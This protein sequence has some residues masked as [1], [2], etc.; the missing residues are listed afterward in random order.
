[1]DTR[2]SGNRPVQVQDKWYELNSVRDGATVWGD[3]GEAVWRDAPEWMES[4]TYL[5]AG[6]I[7]TYP[8]GIMCRKA[9]C[10]A[11]QFVYPCVDC[12]DFEHGDY[13]QTLL[14]SGWEIFRCAPSVEFRNKPGHVHRMVT[15]RKRFLWSDWRWA[16]TSLER[17]TEFAVLAIEQL[18]PD[19]GAH[20]NQAQCLSAKGRCVWASGS[21]VENTCRSNGMYGPGVCTMFG[22]APVL[23]GAR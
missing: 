21:C 20:A 1:M 4:L 8:Y 14:A 10:M 12:P 2:A 7:W 17:P 3:I 6:S 23:T 13:M 22:L 18:P 15:F 5:A 11:Y 19:C 9:H 16:S